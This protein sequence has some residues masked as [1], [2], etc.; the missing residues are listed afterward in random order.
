MTRRCMLQSCADWGYDGFVLKGG[1]KERKKLKGEQAWWITLRRYYSSVLICGAKQVKW[2][3]LAA[4]SAFFSFFLSLFFFFFLN[5]LAFWNESRRTTEERETRRQRQVLME[6]LLE[7]QYEGSGM[8]C[9]V[10]D[11]HGAATC[12]WCTWMSSQGSE[13]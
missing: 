7:I 5:K 4:M 9:G 13:A 1:K 8:C 12:R 11:T 6:G 2:F 10:G 3:K